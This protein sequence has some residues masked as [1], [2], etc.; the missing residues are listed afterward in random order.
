MFWPKSGQSVKKTVKFQNLIF[1]QNKGVYSMQTFKG[2][3][4]VAF[5]LL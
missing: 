3:L 4:V 1:L 5:V 2:K